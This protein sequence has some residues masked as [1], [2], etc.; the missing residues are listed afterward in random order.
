MAYRLFPK[1]LP[2][3]NPFFF[4]AE[5]RLRVYYSHSRMYGHAKFWKKQSEIYRRLHF[6]ALGWVVPSSV[7][8][9]FYHKPSHKM[10]TPSGFYRSCR[11]LVRYSL[12]FI[13][14]LKVEQNYKAFRAGESG[15]TN[16]SPVRLLDTPRHSEKTKQSNLIDTSR[17]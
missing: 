3:M 13:I 2:L 4:Q 5:G 6:Y 12:P 17:R 15:V 1:V 16:V 7:L 9:P 11:R 10:Y 14:W 8:I